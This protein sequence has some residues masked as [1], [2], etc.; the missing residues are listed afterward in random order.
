MHY[1]SILTTIRNN[2]QHIL[3]SNTMRLGDEFRRYGNRRL[4]ALDYETALSDEEYYKGYGYAAIRNRANKVAEVAMENVTTES[5]NDIPHPYL[6][7]IYRSKNFSERKFWSDISTYLDLEGVYYL[8][9]I[10]AIA[11]GRVGSIQQ[12][13]LLNPYKIR[14]V[15]DMNTGDLTGYIESKGNMS[16][17]I[18]KEM[19]IEIKELNPINPDKNFSLADAS[20]SP[21]STLNIASSH[22]RGAVR[23]NMNAPGII[24]TDVILKPEQFENFKARISGHIPG[25]PIFV[26]GAGGVDWKPMTTNLKDTGLEGIVGVSRDELFS[27]TGMSKTTMGIEQ[28]GTTRE[29]SRV[30]MDLLVN[31]HIIPRIMLILD[32]LNMDYVKNYGKEGKDI[33]LTCID[34]TATDA[35]VDQKKIKT[36]SDKFD[37]Y[38]KMVSEG[39]N[40]QEVQK[41]ID[42]EIKLDQLS[43]PK[44][45]EPEPQVQEKQALPEPVVI[46]NETDVTAEIIKTQQR[47]LEN[48]VQQIDTDLMAKAVTR[49]GKIQSGTSNAMNLNKIELTEE[50]VVSSYDRKESTNSLKLALIAFYGILYGI[51]GPKVA[52]DRAKTYN[53]PARFDL[54]EESKKYIEKTATKTAKGHIDTISSDIYSIARDAAKAG[55][56]LTEIQTKLRTQFGGEVSENRAKTVAR[57]ETN[58]AFTRSQYEAD[59]QFIK[60]NRIELQAFKKWVT[61]SGNPCVHCQ[62]LASMSPI[63]FTQAFVLKGEELE[64]EEKKIKIDFESVEAGNLHP[65]CSCTYELIIAKK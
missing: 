12:F 44:K 14:R 60:D 1:M 56:S 23:G 3:Q 38:Q 31:S 57:T 37:L 16:R 43:K 49:I 65:N 42:R 10:R 52:E 8:M 20:S 62:K 50:D 25:E 58:R 63:P 21:Q 40:P 41:Y 53:L 29:T 34:P 9:A 35:D 47:F 61:R 13:K 19:I 46:K 30:Q 39:Y 32:E 26:N 51:N 22:T 59:D 2:L 45:K 55:D 6:D 54:T 7:L 33:Y 17:A 5:K 48:T 64:A 27:I 24:S 28:S 11:P 36:Q 18:P 4:N 15:I